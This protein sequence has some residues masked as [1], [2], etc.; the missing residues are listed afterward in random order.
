[1]LY[2]CLICHVS[3]CLRERV[4]LEKNL[5]T[6]ARSLKNYQF[7]QKNER[8]CIKVSQKKNDKSHNNKTPKC[9]GLI[10]LLCL[11]FFKHFIFQFWSN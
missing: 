9:H 11:F 10:L 5:T 1:M 2:F 6:L 3:I 8:L 7:D 4:Q